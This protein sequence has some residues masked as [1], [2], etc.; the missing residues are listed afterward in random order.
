MVRFFLVTF[1]FLCLQP[2]EVSKSAYAS[3][4][5]KRT[6]FIEG[7]LKGAKSSRFESVVK[8]NLESNGW[9]TASIELHFK[10]QTEVVK[11]INVLEKICMDS[12]HII[13][14]N[15]ALLAKINR[16]TKQNEGIS[17]TAIKMVF[18]GFRK[19]F[20][21]GVN[22]LPFNQLAPYFA[23]TYSIFNQMPQQLC[24]QMWSGRLNQDMNKF[25]LS[26]QGHLP[27]ETQ[28]NYLNLTKKA[29]FAEINNSPPIS[30]IDNTEVGE[31]GQKFGDYLTEYSLKYDNPYQLALILNNMAEGTDKEYCDVGKLYYGAL[32]S[33]PGSD[34]DK[35]RKLIINGLM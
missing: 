31:I 21:S 23:F 14:N 13:L 17:E 20:V 30:V 12:S 29:I 16:E 35:A 11:N 8:K 34:G 4:E 7:C 24:R 2:F 33:M 32:L 15:Q 28:A 19:Y 27:I 3:K 10:Y 26:I 18:Q 9:P 1:L 22:R 5:A 6:A 25:L